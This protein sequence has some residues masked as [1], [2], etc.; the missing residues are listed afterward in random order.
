M[1]WM[2]HFDL[3]SL[4]LSTIFCLKKT[5]FAFRPSGQVGGLFHQHF[6]GLLVI[7]LLRGWVPRGGGSLIF[8]NV[9]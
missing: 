9:P 3:V 7:G 5:G 1:I 4:L 6:Q 2:K 8:P